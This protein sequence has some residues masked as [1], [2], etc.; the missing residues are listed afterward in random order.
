MKQLKLF[1]EWYLK[2][3]LGLK[4][5][6]N[7][8]SGKSLI[9]KEKAIQ[10]AE[11]EELMLFPDPVF[12][13]S[14]LGVNFQGYVEEHEHIFD[15]YT[16]VYDSLGCRDKVSSALDL[17]NFNNAKGSV[18]VFLKICL[19]CNLGGYHVFIRQS[20]QRNH[21]KLSTKVEEWLKFILGQ[22]SIQSTGW[23]KSC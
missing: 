20:G 5:L 21:S 11:K 18:F 13:M 22:F 7:N 1:W 8:F 15:I 2:I 10:I 19:F 6:F 9:G 16:K 23:Y 4:S 14:L 17:W 3:K 12:F